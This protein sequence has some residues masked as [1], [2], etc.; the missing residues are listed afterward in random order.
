[1]TP[2]PPPHPQPPELLQPQLQSD[3]EAPPWLYG[4]L[5]TSASD[6]SPAVPVLGGAEGPLLAPPGL[7]SA[8]VKVKAEGPSPRGW[9]VQG[10]G[11][12]I[13]AEDG[14][15]GA[16]AGAGRGLGLALIKPDP[17]PDPDPDPQ[18]EGDGEGEGGAGAGMVGNGEGDSLAWREA[19]AGEGEGEGVPGLSLSLSWSGPVGAGADGDPELSLSWREAVERIG[20]SPSSLPPPSALLT[21]MMGPG[22]GDLD[23][24]SPA[25]TAFALQQVGRSSL[26][27]RAQSCLT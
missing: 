4:A 7:G 27:G 21:T 12:G 10:L 22:D 18:P 15:A 13:K 16:G 11:L 2:L 26:G 5:A 3:P 9:L 19:A 6:S 23:R 20:S 25:E 24:Q 14:G 1:V 8:K 17:D